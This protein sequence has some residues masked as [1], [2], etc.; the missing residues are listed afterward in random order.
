M[1]PQHRHTDSTEFLATTAT[2]SNTGSQP[3]D[4][5]PGVHE[6]ALPGKA[7]VAFAAQTCPGCTLAALALLP[8]CCCKRGS[9]CAS[10]WPALSVLLGDCAWGSPGALLDGS[11]LR[12]CMWIQ[13]FTGTHFGM[14]TTLYCTKLWPCATHCPAMADSPGTA[15]SATEPELNSAWLPVAPHCRFDLPFHLPCMGALCSCKT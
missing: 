1:R 5:Q 6:A 2:T 9:W 12:N 7:H 14:P 4:H 3:V 10:C 13:L 11:R 15:R 8:L